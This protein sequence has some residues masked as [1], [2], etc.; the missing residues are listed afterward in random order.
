M[1]AGDNPEDDPVS[2]GTALETNLRQLLVLCH[3]HNDSK[4]FSAEQY[5]FLHG[6]LAAM[7]TI[8]GK[9]NKT[10]SYDV[11]KLFIDPINQFSGGF[12][13]LEVNG[14]LPDEAAKQPPTTGNPFLG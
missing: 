1:K 10:I 5:A 14:L 13:T 6:Y 2:N 3:E 12:K 8:K 4:S 9:L 11:R 7:L